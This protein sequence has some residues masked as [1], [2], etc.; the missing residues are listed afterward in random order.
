[1]L[2]RNLREINILK[3]NTSISMKSALVSPVLGTKI[4]ER[5]RGGKGGGEGDVVIKSV[6][7]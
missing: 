7:E 5:G 1:M 6:V 2:N 4:S 3:S